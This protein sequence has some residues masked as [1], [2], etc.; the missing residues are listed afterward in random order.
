MKGV[1]NRIEVEQKD[2][3]IVRAAIEEALARRADREAERIR[4]DVTDGSVTL[5]GTVRSWLEKDAILGSAGHAPGV[6][7]IKDHL[8]VDPFF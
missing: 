3:K 5:S 7:R 1:R 6:E 8:R 4:V 2:P